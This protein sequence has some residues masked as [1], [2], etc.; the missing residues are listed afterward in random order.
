[1]GYAGGLVNRSR[2]DT[3]GR[4]GENVSLWKST[5]N[6]GIAPFV[7]IAEGYFL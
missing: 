3:R 1:M 4:V 2:M 6:T 5:T 7:R